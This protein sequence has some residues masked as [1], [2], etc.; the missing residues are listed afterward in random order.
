MN[1]VCDTVITL[2]GINPKELQ[3]NMFKHKNI[4]MANFIKVIFIRKFVM[5]HMSIDWNRQSVVYS[6]HHYTLIKCKIKGYVPL[7]KKFVNTLRETIKT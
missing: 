2:L 7:Q 4:D 3:T 1:L 6:M 5:T